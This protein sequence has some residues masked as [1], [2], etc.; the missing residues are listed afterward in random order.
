M[1]ISEN[2]FDL[3]A[4]RGSIVNMGVGRIFSMGA[5]G[6]FPKIFSRGG[7]KVVKFG[8][9]PSKLKK[10]PFLLIISKSRG[11]AWPPLLPLPTPRIVNT[12]GVFLCEIELWVGKLFNK[13]G[14]VKWRVWFFF[15]PFYF[16]ARV[17]SAIL[18]AVFGRHTIRPVLS[19]TVPVCRLCPGVP[20]SQ[21]KSSG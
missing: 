8:F 9:Y 10:Q 19:G 4:F 14:I 6:N 13:F 15:G 2:S 21:P 3:I 17:F 18:L 5:V 16:N 11:G 7:P 20:V 1:T 12:Q